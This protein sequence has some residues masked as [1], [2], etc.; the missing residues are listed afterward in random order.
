MLQG[1]IVAMSLVNAGS[2]PEPVAIQFDRW[3]TR[4]RARIAELHVV[5]DFAA[6]DAACDVTVGFAIGANGRPVNPTIR[7]TTCPSYYDRAA[8]RLVRLLGR[9][10]AVP[11]A[12]GYE[13]SVVLKLSYGVAPT[14]AADRQL[15]D[16]LEEE[17]RHHASRNLRIVTTP[18]RTASA[19]R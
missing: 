11:S 9:I 18:L 10:G 19:G 8:L 6:K 16:S 15:T 2:A 3:E 14:L 1:V 17:R 7:E 4:L 12:D 13:H 5:P